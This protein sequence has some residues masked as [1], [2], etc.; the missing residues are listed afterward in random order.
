MYR[1]LR[2]YIYYYLII[3]YFVYL[4]GCNLNIIEVSMWYFVLLLI[5]IR[6]NF[7]ICKGLCNYVVGVRLYIYNVMIDRLIYVCYIVYYFIVFKYII[8]VFMCLKGRNIK[9]EYINDKCKCEIYWYESIGENIIENFIYV[10]L[11]NV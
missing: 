5:K 11:I 8:V 2:D 9:I 10:L 6:V 3:C 4:W 1:G 7:I